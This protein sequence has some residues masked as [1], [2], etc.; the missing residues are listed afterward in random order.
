MFTTEEATEERVA[1]WVAA[2]EEQKASL[3]MRAKRVKG[4]GRDNVDVTLTAEALDQKVKD[5]DDQI[6]WAKKQPGEKAK[7]A[8]K[9]KS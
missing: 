7:K 5:V 1:A 9:S 6:A 2:L 3:Q 8:E 4:G